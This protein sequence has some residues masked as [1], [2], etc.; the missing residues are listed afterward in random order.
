MA[1]KSVKVTI[2]GIS[3]LLMH[4]FPMEPVA[5]MEKKTP[6]EQAEYAAYRDP[7]NKGNLYLPGIAIQ[8]ALIAAAVFSKGKGRASLQKPVAACVMVDPERIPLGVHDFVI[9]SRPVVIPATK[10][11]IIRHRP[12]LD[13]WKASFT[14]EFDDEL[15]TAVQLRTIVDDM[16]KRVG[17]L[18]FRPERKGPFGR[19]AV[20]KWTVA[21]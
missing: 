3:A 19:C 16:G 15:V 2:E 11:R 6:A 18:D 20:T 5:A 8:R 12:R 4:K 21:K 7:D 13:E 17:L 14:I 10:G 9:D 1:T